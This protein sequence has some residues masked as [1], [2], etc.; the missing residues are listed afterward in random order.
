MIE[1]RTTNFTCRKCAAD[2]VMFCWGCEH[3]WCTQ[4]SKNGTKVSGV[5]LCTSCIRIYPHMHIRTEF[6]CR[7]GIIDRQRNLHCFSCD[8]LIY[9]MLDTELLNHH[10][11]HA[12]YERQSRTHVYNAMFTRYQLDMRPWVNEARDNT[13]AR[14]TMRMI[15][16]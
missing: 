5:F 15:G 8:G 9:H 6:H 7:V 12:T 13:V 10:C 14:V 4:H 2:A 16:K 11:H 1:R 3:F